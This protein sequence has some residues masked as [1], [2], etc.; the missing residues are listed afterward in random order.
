MSSVIPNAVNFDALLTSLPQHMNFYLRGILNSANMALFPDAEASTMTEDH[1]SGEFLE[2]LRLAIDTAHPNLQEGDIVGFGY[3]DIRKIL[4]GESIFAKE[5]KYA[6]ETIGEQIRTSLGSFGVT[7]KDGQVQIFDTYD[8]LPQGGFERFLEDIGTGMYPAART[9]GGILMPENPDGSSKEDAMRVRINLPQ[10]PNVID[11]DFDDEPDEDAGD[12]VFRGPMTNRRKKIWDN[13][14]GMLRDAAEQL[15]P[16]SDANAD[17]L[18]D[19]IPLGIS[20]EQTKKIYE[21]YSKELVGRGAV[22]AM[23]S[24]LTPLSPDTDTSFLDQ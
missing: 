13:F 10:E 3:K 16:I 4:G 19:V 1:V 8:F 2:A 15:N 18:D 11:V 12:F 23:G 20:G 14:T 6:I 5:D 24:A 22:P 7:M 21:L 17:Q 9:L